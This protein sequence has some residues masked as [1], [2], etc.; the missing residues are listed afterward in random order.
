[1][2]NDS[3]RLNLDDFSSELVVRSITTNDIETI[4]ELARRA[5]PTMKP[6]SPEQLE[7]QIEIF[8]EGQRLIEYDGRVVAS[9]SS[10]I[11]DFAIHSDWHNWKAISDSGYIRTHDPDGDTLYG[12]EIMVDPEFRGRRLAR[13][14][15]EER[16]RIAREFNCKRCIVGGR[17]PGYQA[18]CEELTAREYVDKVVRKE[19]F[20][21]VLTPQL[22]NGFQLKRLI[23][24][25][26]PADGESKGYATFLE[27]INLDFIPDTKQSEQPVSRVRLCVIQYQMR[28]IHSFEDF[29]KQCAYFVE[30][31]SDY[32]S[33]FICFPELFTTQLLSTIAPDRPGLAAR[34]LADYTPRYLEMFTDLAIRYHI[35]IVGGSQF[36]V[37]DDVLYNIAYLF[38]RDGTIERQYKIHI[39]PNERKWWG[40]EAGNEVRVFD[41][42]R[43]KISI[44]ICYDVEFPELARVAAQKGA[45]ILFVPFNTDERNGYLR[46]RYCAQARAIENHMFTVISGCVGNLPFV[47]NADMHFAQSAIFTP[48]DFAFSREAIAAEATENMESILVQDVDVELLRR[49][50]KTGTV[51][52]WADRRRDLYTLRFRDPSG[53]LEI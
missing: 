2:S 38:R 33:D 8:P 14:L 47:E 24:N 10:L 21:P 40:V 53:I 50:K 44:A 20:D 46:V 36:A 9:C 41:T 31:G 13:R 27:W 4:R 12:I 45:R 15:Y 17:I 30:V 5:F 18:Y 7:S 11:V 48:A 28:T 51:K 19:L 42:D 6:W 1:M 26:E 52:N 22:S 16:F 35:N 25:Y 43:G 3:S 23:P 49:H 32:R 39:T 34:R 37:E 29:E